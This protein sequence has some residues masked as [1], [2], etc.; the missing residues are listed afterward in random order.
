M[1]GTMKQCPV[2]GEYCFEI[3]DGST[4]N[5]KCKPQWDCYERND[6]TEEDAR[7]V[8]G[9]DEED[10]AENY[11]ELIEQE[12]DHQNEEYEIMVRLRDEEGAR[13]NLYN[14]QAE[15]VREYTA[16]LIEGNE[17]GQ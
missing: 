14:V 10:A 11:A 2:C 6:E 3:A 13:W 15:T 7:V 12:G 8:R 1:E 4:S 16:R 9:I 17:D 5:H